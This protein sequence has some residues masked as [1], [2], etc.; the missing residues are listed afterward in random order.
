MYLLY[1]FISQK[2]TPPKAK[3][4]K[5]WGLYPT[6]AEKRTKGQLWRTNRVYKQKKQ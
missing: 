3:I 5:L 1:H 4:R 6:V 2:N